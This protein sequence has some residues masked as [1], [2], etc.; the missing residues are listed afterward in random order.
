MPIPGSSRSRTRPTA[1]T[2]YEGAF[3]WHWHN[4]WDDRIQEGSKFHRL[5]ALIDQT[6]QTMELRTLSSGQAKA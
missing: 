1:R 4:R 2:L 3:A 5:E 6:L